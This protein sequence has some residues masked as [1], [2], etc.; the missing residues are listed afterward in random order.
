MSS[1]GPVK[2]RRCAPLSRLWAIVSGVPL[3]TLP[4]RILLFGSTGL[5]GRH[6]APLLAESGATLECPSHAACDIADERAVRETIERCRPELVINCAA[7]NAVDRAEQEPD[8]ALRVNALGPELL[9]RNA[10]RLV[11]FSTDFVFGDR[12]D[13]PFV[14][15]DPP[16][17]LS[18][19]GRAKAE[20]D[21]RVLQ[22]SPNN[23]LVRVGC[24]YGAGTRGF[25]SNVI[26][27]L[28]AGERI[29]ADAERRV[30]PTWVRPLAE[31]IVL[32]ISRGATGLFHAMSHGET[33]WYDF[34]RTLAER[35]G[36]D[37][38]LIEPVSTESL[39]AP[40]R[41]PHDAVLENRNLQRMGLDR[42]PHWRDGL[43]GYLR[44][45]LG[46]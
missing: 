14:E 30:Q 4:R 35:A 31:Q 46:R 5:L 15:D 28:R 1:T 40:A 3:P 38:G 20:G 23:L 29:R 25:G 39:G 16:S 32:L 42:M 34:A 2:E 9:A 22:A 6:L 13:R 33:T 44:E 12:S 7:Y 19:Y 18:A 43:D 17:P 24:L 36:F 37:G 8:E 45:E 10:P 41:R 11:H 27:R 21:R 26:H